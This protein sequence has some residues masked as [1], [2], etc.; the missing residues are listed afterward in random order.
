MYFF[1]S[2]GI[3]QILTAKNNDNNMGARLLYMYS[4]TFFQ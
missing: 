4:T 1:A 3:N 2:F